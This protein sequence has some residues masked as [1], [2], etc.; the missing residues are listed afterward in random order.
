MSQLKD[1]DKEV[2]NN[3]LHTLPPLS[4]SPQTSRRRR[5]IKVRTAKQKKINLLLPPINYEIS[6]SG[7]EKH[8]LVSYP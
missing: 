6:L 4:S 7:G 5:T 3:S 1:C 2:W 8:Y